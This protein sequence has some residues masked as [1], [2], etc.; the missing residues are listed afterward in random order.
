M[1]AS[2]TEITAFV[3]VAK[4]GQKSCLTIRLSRQ[5]KTATLV[6]KTGVSSYRKKGVNLLKYVN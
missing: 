6:S 4:G 2:L 1:K 3:R 5:I